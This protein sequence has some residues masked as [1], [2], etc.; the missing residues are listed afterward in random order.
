MQHS[1]DSNEFLAGLPVERA[2]ALRRRRPPAAIHCRSAVI[3]T[4]KG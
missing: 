1:N 3:H 2:A 4:L